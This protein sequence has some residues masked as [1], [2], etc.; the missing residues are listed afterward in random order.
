MDLAWAVRCRRVD[1]RWL[2]VAAN[3]A[4]AARSCN[5]CACSAATS[6][7]LG[8]GEDAEAVPTPVAI[9]PTTSAA[10]TRSLIVNGML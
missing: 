7:A 1:C 2:S 6:A 8:D 10:T 4:M 3:P 9:P 5:S